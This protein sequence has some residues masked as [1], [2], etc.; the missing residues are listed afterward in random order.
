MGGR[1]KTPGLR[2]LGKIV[3]LLGLLP[4][5]IFAASAQAQTYSQLQVL[6][7]GE[8][9][10]P[11]TGSGKSGI[12]LDQTVG[13]PFD[14]VV[15]ACDSSWNLVPSVTNVVSFT[16]TD[17]GATL[18][19][20]T[21]LSGGQAT[22]SV[23]F[24]SDGS[25][26]IT[27]DDETDGTIP[28]AVS[29]PVTAF[30]LAGFEF[31]RINQKN[32][33]AGI[34]MTITVTA[35]DPNDNPVPG[36]AGEI[37]LEELT[38]YGLGRISPETVTLSGGTW[39]GQVT[40]YRADETSI[41]RGNV[42][43]RAFLD[44]NPSIQGTSDPFVVHPGP[45]HRVQIVVPGETPWPGS[46]PGVSGTPASQGAGQNFL[47][48][49]F[50]TDQWWNPLPTS[51]V[52]R[53]TSSDPA[54]STPVTGALANGY[55]QFSLSL[56][57]VGSQTLTVTDMTDG[58]KVPMTSAPIPVSASSAHHFVIEPFASPVTA[59]DSVDVTI[60]AT[61][62]SDNTI[63]DFNGNANLFANTGPGSISPEFITFSNGIWAGKMVF[64]G[65]GGAVAFTC[66]DFSSPPH[67]G[68]SAT[69]VV[70]PG[71][72]T[73]LQVLADGQT[74]QGGTASGYSGVPAS[75][76]AGSSFDIRIRAVDAYWNRVPGINDR[77][78]LSSTDPFA[79]MPAE[80]T[81]VNGE[82]LLPV[83]LYAAGDRTITASD[84]DSTSI[85]DH[86]SS[87]IPVLS[88]PYSRILLI[89]PGEQIAQGTVDGRTGTATDQ[90]INFAFTV[91]VYA[92]DSWWNPVNTVTDV[93]RLTSGDP[94]AEL[95]PDT[96]M[97]D[98]R[99]DM[100]IRL[101]T[102]GFQQIT[103]ENVSQG[104]PTSTTQVRAI[105]SG[106][107]LEATTSASAVQA[108]EPFTL[109]V[110]VRNDAGSI[111]QE[112]NSFV[113]VEVRNSSTQE[114]GEGTLLLTR[115]QLIQGQR[116]IQETYTFAEPIILVIRDDAG[117]DPAVTDVIDVSPGPPAEV[118]LSADPEWVGGDK[119]STIS[120]QVADEFGNG[121]TGEPVAFSL[122]S[123]TGL[124]TALDDTTNSEGVAQADF[125]SPRHPEIDRIRATSGGLFA[126]LDIET[127]LVD[128]AKPAGTI[129][130][131]PNP[132][133]P[134][135]APTTVAYKLSADADVQ[136]RIY[137]LLGAEVLVKQL[138]SGSTGGL[139]GLNE[140][141]WD[142]RNGRGEIVASGGY[143]LVLEATRTG[144]TLHVMRR[145]IAVVR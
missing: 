49:V 145:R 76:N 15:R 38:S 101:S 125:L 51:D 73:G 61:D 71:P 53:I 90:S 143:V 36:F 45:F 3:C 83:T 33:Y 19:G 135:E 43:I 34:P 72:F 11:G 77:V 28:Q 141:H 130:S 99:A 21:S 126:E 13:I 69:F 98:G 54:A 44:S 84:V 58:T 68:T 32:Q 82:L 131:Y 20:N 134:G 87:P 102:G 14:V 138:P 88:G 121:V 140:F 116:A 127:A 2:G 124:L 47:V 26:T 17:I 4:G 46:I 89:A 74:P 56:G 114:P 110:S 86:T 139:Q 12:P 30:L 65:A 40:N 39:T 96:P 37:R 120:A 22:V 132:F 23:A 117:N 9:P 42:N 95:P 112:I 85:A 27:A 70:Q 107:H 78:A 5:I 103:A 105:S 128:P 136:I 111:I 1:S 10:A 79:A 50:G 97:V 18:P 64:R 92:T 67:T 113:D 80:T 57:T 60:R 94:L 100:S 24:N 66:S 93:I 104:M 25:F 109:S 35:I 55:A 48:E 115:F 123:G 142:G 106:F 6:L 8:S 41:N 118:L 81:L 59:G 31:D 63:P 119:H 52:V 29:S 16:S 75:Q 7:P 137:S 108:G 144:E 122:V 62:I 133:H 129:T 91:S